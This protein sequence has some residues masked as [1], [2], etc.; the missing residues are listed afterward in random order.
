MKIAVLTWFDNMNY[1]TVLQLHAL[2]DYLGETF[3]ADV[4]VINYKPS[5][6]HAV[7]KTET[8]SDR[9]FYRLSQALK[10]NLAPAPAASV[11]F[12]KE[13]ETKKLRFESFLGGLSFTEPVSETDELE[14]LSE[15]YDLFVCGSDQIWNPRILNRVFYLDFVKNTP[16]LSY[17]TSMGIGYIPRYAEKYI[18]DYLKDF[19][20][21]SLREDSCK[22]RL[23]TICGK[24]VSVVCDPTLLLSA[25]KWGA[26][27]DS[28][29]FVG[30]GYTFTYFLGSS[31]NHK[32]INREVLSLLGKKAYTTAPSY[33]YSDLIG[34]EETAFGPLEFLSAVKN[35]DFVL[36]DSFH[37]VCFCIIFEVPF[38]VVFKHSESDPFNQNGRITFL[39]E[40]L[41]L[42]DR[43]AR[44]KEDVERIINTGVDY[45]SVKE[46]LDEFIK[47]SAAY[48]DKNIY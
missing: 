42:S 9:L 19:R 3:S 8:L 13:E 47:E 11:L 43:I 32:E 39:L 6:A 45:K 48:L 28:A 25:E 41:S 44:G 34:A 16:K 30:S 23:E 40:K 7:S 1:G 33:D 15:N 14:K 4:D 12:P 18:K 46:K 37:A 35:S 29:E 5:D 31:E 22:A 26:L 24:E 36:T 10:K 2:C 38:C 27:A 17:A 21:V 20:A